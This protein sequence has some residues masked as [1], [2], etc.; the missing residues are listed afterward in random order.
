MA[1]DDDRKVHDIKGGGYL[2]FCPACGHGH[3][4]D[5]RW[6]FNGDYDKPTFNPS[7]HSN[8]PGPKHAVRAPSCHSFVRNGKIE[9]QNDCTHDMAGQT[10]DL[11]EF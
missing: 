5:E 8:P 9:F 11:P 6:T 3:K 1:D 2:I 4:F 10:V 7:M